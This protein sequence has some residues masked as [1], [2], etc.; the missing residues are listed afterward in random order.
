MLLLPNLPQMIIAFYGT[1]RAGGTAVFTLPTTEPDELFRQV[2]DCG[3]RVL[4]TLTQF[5]EL[6]HQI[7]SQ[8]EA[9]GNSPLKHTQKT[10]TPFLGIRKPVTCLQGVRHQVVV[11][12]HN[13]FRGAGCTSSVNDD[14]QVL[15]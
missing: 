14:R 6:V 9:E 3:A 1:L 15:W 2:C 13:P 11:G 5:S 8:I 4:V 10:F 7:E 12:E